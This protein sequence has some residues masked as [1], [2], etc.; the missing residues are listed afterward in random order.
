MQQNGT[1]IT[2]HT[3]Y[4]IGLLLVMHLCACSLLVLHLVEMELTTY[5]WVVQ[6][7]I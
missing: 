1:F 6:E 4:I 5:R 3:Y 7:C 2:I